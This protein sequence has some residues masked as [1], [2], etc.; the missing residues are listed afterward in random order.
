MHV[1]RSRNATVCYLRDYS[2]NVIKNWR[3]QIDF[4]FIDGDHSYN[5]CLKD[6]Q[7]WSVFVKKGGILA[8]HDARTFLGGWTQPDWGPVKV[9]NELFREKAER[10]W[11]LID[12]VDSLVVLERA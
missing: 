4:L 9:V 10:G 12:E 7:E 8:F 11:R 3:L 5:A 2:F 6:W 1:A